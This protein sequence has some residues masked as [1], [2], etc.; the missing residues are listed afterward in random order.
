[1]KAIIDLEKGLYLKNEISDEEEAC[2]LQNGYE[3]CKGRTTKDGG[4]TW[5]FVK[6]RHNE[7]AE[8]AYLCWVTYELALK[9]FDKVEMN[10][11]SGGDVI[12]DT[13]TKRVAFEIETGSNLTRHTDE[14]LKEKFQ[15]LTENFD[16]YYIIA[17]DYD[18]Q[19]RYRKYG[20]VILRNKIEETLAGIGRQ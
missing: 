10:A 8:H 16:D 19:K 9:R 1:M 2:L 4:S 5:F 12:I 6:V 3:P 11:T 7:G 15:R 13:G 17:S 20:K 14:F 18:F